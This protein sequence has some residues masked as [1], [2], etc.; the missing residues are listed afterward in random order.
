MLGEL[1]DEDGDE[2]VVVDAEDDFEGGQGEEG[3]E[4]GG[5]EEG[6][7]VAGGCGGGGGEEV[8]SEVHDRLLCERKM[9]GNVARAGERHNGVSAGR[10]DWRAT[11]RRCNRGAWRFG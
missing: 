11:S 4:A 10:R 2:D 8:E 9:G 6:D 1:G 5:G 7:G 3:D